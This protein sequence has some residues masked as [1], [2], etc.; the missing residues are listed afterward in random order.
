M[1]LIEVKNLR[2]VFTRG[3]EEIVALSDISFSVEAGE[4]LA[5]TGPSGSGKSTLM[6]VLGLLDTATG[7]SYFLNGQETITLTDEERAKLRCQSIGFI[8][9]SFHLLP[10]ATARRNVMIPLVYA[11]AH[12]IRVSEVEMGVRA[13]AALTR[14]GLGDRL[15]HRP[16][17]LSGGQSQRVAIARA[18]VNNPSIIFADEPTGN[19]DTKTGEEILSLLKELNAKGVTVILVSHDMKIAHSAKRLI[20]IVDG[21]LVADERC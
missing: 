4:F 19:L 8:F 20:T 13:D 14:V 5:I 16:N 1:A 2:K 9:Q 6:Y 3:S 15:N 21:K 7:G 10:R 11:A 17:E 18:I 12:G